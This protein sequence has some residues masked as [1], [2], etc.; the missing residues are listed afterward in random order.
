MSDIVTEAA[1]QQWLE[2]TKLTITSIDQE[3]ELS[4]QST[5]FSQVSSRYDT[6]GWVD[7]STTPPLIRSVVSMFIA[8]WIYN[9]A[10]S[11]ATQDSNSWGN[12]LLSSAALIISG[13]VNGA[14]DIPDQDPDLSPL[15][16]PIF[17][18]DDASTQS[19]PDNFGI[20]FTMGK[21]F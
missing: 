5:V 17:F 9:R 6:S 3:L 1:I 11:E 12:Y 13:I 7:V 14:V 4:A 2:S 18:P 16:Q 10:Y 21:I 19:D 8:G 20:K 15:A